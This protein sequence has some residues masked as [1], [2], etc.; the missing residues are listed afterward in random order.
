MT[1]DDVL[2]KIRQ[3]RVINIQLV[4]GYCAVCYKRTVRAVSIYQLRPEVIPLCQAH[5][6]EVEKPLHEALDRRAQQT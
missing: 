2:M 6:D 5:L 4:D 3:A 1:I